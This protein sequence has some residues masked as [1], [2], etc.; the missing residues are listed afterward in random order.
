M[1]A[2]EGLTPV[3][4]DH[5]T[6]GLSGAEVIAEYLDWTPGPEARRW[7]ADAAG[8][9]APGRGPAGSRTWFNAKLFNKNSVN[10]LY[11]KRSTSAL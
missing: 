3:M 7:P 2:P 6:P 8:P 1:M 4:I 10:G 11:G 9:V 5:E